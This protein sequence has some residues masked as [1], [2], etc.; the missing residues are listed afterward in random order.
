M[1]ELVSGKMAE[2]LHKPDETNVFTQ[3]HAF[4]ADIPQ[5]CVLF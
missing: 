4:N 5:Q 1:E 3:A 2:Y